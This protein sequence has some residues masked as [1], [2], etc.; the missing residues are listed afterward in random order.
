M[1]YALCI[2]Y[3]GTHFKGW[4]RQPALRTVQGE[5]EKALAFVANEP[6]K[7]ICAGRTDAGVHA[8]HQIIHFETNAVRENHAWLLGANAQLPKDAAIQ[9]VIKARDDFHARYCATARRYRYFIANM[10][11]RSALLRDRVCW[12]PRALD[13]EKMHQAGQCLLGSHDFSAFRASDCQAKTPVRQIGFLDIVRTGEMIMIDIQAN[14]FLH[15]MVRNIVG[16]LLDIGSGRE[17]VEKMAQVLLSCD[18]SKAG[19]TA[20]ASGLYM[21]DVHYPEEYDLPQTPLLNL[22][23]QGNDEQ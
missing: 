14:A 23:K 3:D 13:H 15:H 1:K 21:V 18:R 20:R 5:L 17:P 12:F 16:V 10:S 6:V 22:L 2:D 7:V 11:A 9:W 19:R 4:Q 8:A